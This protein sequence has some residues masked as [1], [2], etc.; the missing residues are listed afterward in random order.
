MASLTFLSPGERMDLL[1][2]KK[3][4][5]ARQRFIVDALRA[6]RHFRAPP[7]VS[8]F[9]AVGLS[10]REC[11]EEP[12]GVLTAAMADVKDGFHRLRT[13]GWLQ[14]YFCLAPL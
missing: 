3:E 4:G 12:S 5:G 9:T 10:A 13:P 7:P 1:V 8:L 14:R 11:V 2:V 6:N